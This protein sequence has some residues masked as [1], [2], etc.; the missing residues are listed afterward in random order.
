MLKSE[1][2]PMLRDERKKSFIVYENGILEVT[3]DTKE[4]VGFMDVEGFV[5]ESQIL[6]RNYVEHKNYKNDYQTFIS[7]ISNNS[8][9]ALECVLGYLISTYKNKMNNK[10]IILNDEVISD[11][12]EGG[13]GKGLMIQGLKRIRKT[14]ILDGKSFDDKKGF[15]YQTVSLDSQILV[16]DDVKS[17]FNFESKFSLVTEGLTIER[18]NK[19]AIKLSV[20]DSPKIVIS[21]NYVIK[22]DG[23]SHDRR[24]H[25]IEIAQYYGKDLTPFDEFG[26]Q[27]F[28][29]WN[30]EEF[31][32][33]DNYMVY[34]L[35]QYLQFGLIAHEAKNLKQRK[36]IAQTSKDFFDWVEDD[37][38]ILNQRLLKS[39]FFQ[40]FTNDNQD[41][42][43]KIFKRNTLNR[44]VQKYADYKGYDFEQNSSNGVKWF[45]LSTKDN[46]VVAELDEVPF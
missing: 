31:E 19:D 44:W 11:N 33:F 39:D 17:G 4:L 41:Y 43:N 36:I 38:L 27:L 7:N 18:K 6:K 25:E 20:E 14:S 34:C 21:T 12:P 2:L 28:D 42:N 29:D 15:P 40:K 8:P 13:T 5:W 23:N 26:K 35:Q 32:L 16:W 46:I 10:A 1:E 24:R 9:K 37:N 45:S 30:A 3:K 22:G